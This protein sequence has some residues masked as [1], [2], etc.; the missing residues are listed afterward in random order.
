[1]TSLLGDTRDI[2]TSQRDSPSG[3]EE[4]ATMSPKASSENW[5]ESSKGAEPSLSLQ[6]ISISEDHS[7]MLSLLDFSLEATPTFLPRTANPRQAAPNLGVA[8]AEQL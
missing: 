4:A 7:Q 5:L 2:K 6:R 1:M 8:S 3:R